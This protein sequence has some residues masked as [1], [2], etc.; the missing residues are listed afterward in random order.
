MQTVKTLFSRREGSTTGTR[1]VSIIYIK[2]KKFQYRKKIFSVDLSS[3]SSTLYIIYFSIEQQKS[4]YKIFIFDTFNLSPLKALPDISRVDW[5]KFNLDESVY[6][7]RSIPVTFITKPWAYSSEIPLL[8][9][10]KYER[11]CD[12]IQALHWGKRAISREI[13]SVDTHS[14]LGL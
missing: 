6:W 5:F 11:W 14:S 8:A 3:D 13:K 1:E 10:T 2:S 7:S 12:R 9:N 4:H